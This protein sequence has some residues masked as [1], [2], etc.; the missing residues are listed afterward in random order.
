VLARFADRVALVTGAGSGLGR[1]LALRLAAEGAGVLVGD[2]DGDRAD[3]VA[4]E[5]AE[6]R[7]R[8]VAARADVARGDEVASM[9]RAARERL[10]A[11]DLLVNNAAQ[12]SDEELVEKTEE[13][14][15]REVAVT[16]KGAFLCSREVLPGMV[17][18]GGGTILSIGS[19][20]GQAYFGNEAYSAAKA[21]LV[22]LTRSI[23]V[24]YGPRGVRANLVA[25]GTLRTPAWDER[26]ARDPRAL[27]R[28]A[29]WYPLGRVGEPEDV[30]G[31][32]LF[33]LSDEA[34]WI[35]G[36]VL[37]VDGGLLAGNGPMARDVLGEEG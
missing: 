37:P 14:W 1:L 24:R 28:V 31:P 21:G 30:V 17:E 8:A 19:V 15:D 3:S 36:A 22:S 20:N 27:E 6:A 16:L 2:V 12:T 10:G 11:V 5:I 32:S 9:V 35:S 18:R 33:L 13:A 25:P 23:A 4:R 7:G 29:R 34:S 26:L